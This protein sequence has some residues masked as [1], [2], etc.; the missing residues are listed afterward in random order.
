[1]IEKIGNIV[2]INGTLLDITKIRVIEELSG[3]WESIGKSPNSLA[4]A[5]A[6]VGCNI[7]FEP[8]VYPFTKPEISL[9]LII[10]RIYNSYEN[11][12]AKVLEDFKY[13][14]EFVDYGALKELFIIQNTSETDLPLLIEQIKS[15]IGIKEIE[16]RFKGVGHEK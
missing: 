11:D 15:D 10:K 8:Q 5:T 14:N 9:F 7:I 12:M 4:Q 6:V 1:M 3:Y 16:G 2:N 13:H